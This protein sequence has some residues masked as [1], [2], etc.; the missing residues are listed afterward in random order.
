M[1]S[2]RGRSHPDAAE[3]LLSRAPE[4]ESRSR[5][6]GIYFARVTDIKDPEKQ[7]RIKV[8]FHWLEDDDAGEM[9]SGWLTRCV[10]FVGPTDMKRGRL[11]GMNW[12][13]PEVGS[14]VVIAFNGGD[15]HDGVFFGQPEYRENDVGAPPTEKDK[16]IDWSLRLALQNGFEIGVDTDGNC[17]L[18]VPGNLRVRGKCDVH[19]SAKGILNMLGIAAIRVLPSSVLRLIGVTIDQ[20]NYPRP[21]EWLEIREMMIDAAK[22]PPGRKDPGIRKIKDIE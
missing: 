15:V 6:L 10:P 17:Y 14:L 9:E 11:F 2:Y 12:P 3:H 1:S 18:E 7:G 22:G 19:V 20:S 13:L 16:H 8:K 5:L 21:E 4:E